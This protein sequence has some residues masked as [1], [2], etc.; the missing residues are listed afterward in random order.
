MRHIIEVRLKNRL[1]RFI[2]IKGDLIEFLIKETK[3]ENVKLA[4]NRIDVASKDLSEAIFFS[5]E[6]FGFQID[7]VDDFKSFKEKNHIL[8]SVLKKYGKYNFSKVLRIGTKSS[9]LIHQKGKGIDVIKEKYK[10]LF[11]KNNKK[12]EENIGFNLTDVGYFFQD[13]EKNGNKLNLLSGPVT[14]TEA[15]NRFFDGKEKYKTYSKENGIYLD[16]DFY[17]L[18]EQEIS[19][20]DKLKD[21]IDKNIDSIEK[22]FQGFMKYIEDK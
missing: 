7:A 9:I 19:D 1:F 8:F 4:Q 21:K 14:K 2:D 5:W 22:I 10:E 16:I 11:F 20:L 12:L 18:E 6:N 13:L 3:Y 15:I 17:Q